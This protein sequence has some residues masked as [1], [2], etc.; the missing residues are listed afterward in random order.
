MGFFAPKTMS[1]QEGTDARPL[2]LGAADGFGAGD[3][4]GG[5]ALLDHADVGPLCRVGRERIRG[6]G[7]TLQPDIGQVAEIARPGAA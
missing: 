2:R 5:V 4:R 1:S 7:C 3:T 6:E